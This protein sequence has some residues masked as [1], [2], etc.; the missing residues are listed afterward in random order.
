MTSATPARRSLLKGA[1]WGIPVL[2]AS[3]LVPLAA[4]TG[5]GGPVPGSEANYYWSQ[6]AGTGLI[7]L[8]PA[9]SNR[10]FQLST[11]ISYTANP[12]VNPPS[13]AILQ[14]SISFTQPVT[15]ESLGWGWTNLTGAGPSTTFVFQLTP[16]GQGGSL[17]ASFLGTQAGNITA[18]ATMLL[19]NGGTTTWAQES[20]VD[21]DVLVD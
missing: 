2:T 13:G 5:G 9:E 6:A 14:V 21:D 19:L 20:V 17:T 12:Y 4:A 10:R 15:I 11:Q 18:T 16:S 3:T 1:A 7:S 8:E